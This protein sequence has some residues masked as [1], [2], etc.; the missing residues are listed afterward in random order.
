MSVPN[1]FGRNP[2]HN[3]SVILPWQRFPPSLINACAKKKVPCP[4]DV[5]DMIYIIAEYLI[6]VFKNDSREMIKTVATSICRRY[7]QSFEMKLD[8]G[9]V[10]DGS[11]KLEL[12]I[13]KMVRYQK[14]FNPTTKRRNCVNKKR[15]KTTSTIKS[16]GDDRKC[17]R[18]EYGFAAWQPKLS[19]H[20]TPETQN[21]KKQFL[22][23]ESNK[24]TSY[25]NE[26]KIDQALK[27][28]YPTQRREINQRTNKSVF[29]I[30]QEWPI[31]KEQ[32]HFFDHAS[33]LLDKRVLN[34]FYCNIDAH[35]V[36]HD[37]MKQCCLSLNK[38]NTAKIDRIKTILIKSST[39]ATQMKNE[40]ARA[41]AIFSLVLEYF[42][43]KNAL[44]EVMNETS[45]DKGIEETINVETPFVVILGSSEYDPA[46]K[47]VIFIEGRICF[48]SQQTVDAIFL[49]FLSYYVFGYKYPLECEKTLQFIQRAFLDIK[50][51][52]EERLKR[53]KL[54][55]D[56]I[57]LNVTKFYEQ[58][59]AYREF[60][61]S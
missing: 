30:L 56:T 48:R 7:P 50:Y 59:R 34:D 4:H 52:D 41:I 9:K 14:S 28:T 38:N 6:D 16:R 39:A 25:R 5:A 26:S 18:D 10:E 35:L 53:C 60:R 19:M 31:L 11:T 22:M 51:S 46:A 58:L 8:N 43:E 55:V 12:S 20:E 40:K 17:T 29:E 57:D 42:E 47:S 36:I 61:K 13:M 49:A 1:I 44:F 32:R 54:K 27:D 21:M 15:K 23:E 45:T 37:F 2:S 3:G 24:L 33:T